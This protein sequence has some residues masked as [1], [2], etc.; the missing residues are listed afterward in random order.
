MHVSQM[1]ACLSMVGLQIGG[2]LQS[3]DQW[4]RCTAIAGE[5]VSSIKDVPGWNE[6]LASDSEA[7]VRSNKLASQKLLYLL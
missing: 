7:A 4:L 6:K 5:Q 3:V 1:S 2:A